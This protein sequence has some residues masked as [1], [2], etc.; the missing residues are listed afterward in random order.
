VI[1]EISENL[2][3]Q[4]MNLENSWIWAVSG[5]RQWDFAEFFAVSIDTAEFIEEFD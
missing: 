2:D 1:D 4:E 3:Y 5:F